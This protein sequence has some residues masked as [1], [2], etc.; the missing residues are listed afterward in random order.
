MKPQIAIVIRK[1]NV[2]SIVSTSADVKILLIDHDNID[3]EQENG[4]QSNIEYIIDG[5]LSKET[6][7]N[8]VKD[9]LKEI[10]KRFCIKFIRDEEVLDQTE[11]D[12]NDEELIWGLFS[13]FGH[14][15]QEGDSYEVEEIDILSG[16]EDEDETET[17]E[18]F[19]KAATSTTEEE[20]IERLI[21][22]IDKYEEGDFVVSQ[23]LINYLWDY[24][25]KIRE[26]NSRE[27]NTK[28]DIL[29][30]AAILSDHFMDKLRE[31]VGYIEA[32]SK[33]AEEAIKFQYKYRDVADKDWD[34][35]IE[36]NGDGATSW[37]DFVVLYGSKQF[38]IP[39]GLVTADFKKAKAIE[40]AS[41]YLSNSEYTIDEQI[42]E[43]LAHPNKSE[44]LINLKKT[45]PIDGFE[46]RSIEDFLDLIGL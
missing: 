14:T 35:F 38:N 6:F 28:T 26:S 7:K 42:E 4:I 36:Q 18:Q 5:H 2:Q 10:P 9:Q 23:G 39:I 41:Y 25:N 15:R 20:A 3:A 32:C 31:E 33:I 8:F 17:I 1:G 21:H 34:E 13:E 11:V 19:G 29:M 22:K 27:K 16:A 37:D 45:N 24:L 12:E 46:Y 44:P 30:I 40:T 43:M